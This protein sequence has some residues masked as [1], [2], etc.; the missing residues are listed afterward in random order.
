VN[1]TREI[2]NCGAQRP[3]KHATRHALLMLL[4]CSIAGCDLPG[5]PK[6]ADQYMPP[7]KKMTFSV[8]FQEN[9]IGCH[10]AN[11][12]LG[13]APPLNDGLFLALVTD[14]ELEHIISQGRAG[15]L[16]PAFSADQGGQL[17][18]AQIKVLVEGVAQSWR[19]MKHAPKG[20]P[21]YL[22]SQTKTNSA[23][24][25]NKE[26]GLK[27]F[28]RACASC[29]GK[30]GQGGRYGGEADGKPVGAINDPNF[31]AL[32]SDQA[33]RR[34]VITGRPDLGMPDYAGTM[35][36]PADFQAL[37]AKNVTDIVALLGSWRTEAVNVKRN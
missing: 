1:F 28:T 11:G 21:P 33:L 9:C 26:D 6:G 36:R 31:L 8:L 22:A 37:T 19:S 10:G 18:D 23:A 13:P 20:A 7:Q 27:V 3:R 24:P 14:K 35:G 16:M 12:K 5:K 4:V 29:H 25:G 30:N 34:Y 15:T 2:A 17:T 32:I